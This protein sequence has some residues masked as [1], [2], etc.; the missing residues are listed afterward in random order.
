MQ[1]DLAD[2]SD[3]STSNSN[4]EWLLSGGDVFTRKSYIVPM[5]NNT[6]SNVTEAMKIILKKV[7]QIV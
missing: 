5:K 6:A 3:I 7:N 4:Y 2:V 1:L